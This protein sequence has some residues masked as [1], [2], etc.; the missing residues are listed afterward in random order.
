MNL[1]KIVAALSFAAILPTTAFAHGELWY[2]AASHLPQFKKLVVYPLRGLDGEFKIDSNEKSE[3]YQ[4]NDYFDKRFV[5]KLKIKTT[6]A[7]SADEFT[8]ANI[9]SLGVAFQPE[10]HVSAD[11]HRVKELTSGCRMTELPDYTRVKSEET[12]E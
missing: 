8:Q 6:G 9:T 11:K 7:D 10:T 5:R 3:V 12:G 4:A 2:D 1:K